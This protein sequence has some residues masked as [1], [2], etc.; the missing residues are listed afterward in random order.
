MWQG[1]EGLCWRNQEQRRFPTQAKQR[2]RLLLLPLEILKKNNKN[3]WQKK[4]KSTRRI[5]HFKQQPRM[6][7]NLSQHTR[8]ARKIY[9][10]KTEIF[11]KLLLFPFPSHC[12][13]LSSQPWL[14]RQGEFPLLP[15]PITFLPLCPE[16]Q[17]SN[18]IL[19]PSRGFLPKAQLWLH[20]PH[21]PHKAQPSPGS[22]TGVSPQQGQGTP[23]CPPACPGVTGM[24]SHRAGHRESQG[25]T[26]SSP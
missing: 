2:H 16:N 21:T 8:L 10:R 20:V 14:E 11:Q 6:I 15:L 13:S 22:V 26:R 4:K 17:F 3:K 12:L 24:V 19:S 5:W 7:H 25:R 23:G 1:R 18:W 9:W